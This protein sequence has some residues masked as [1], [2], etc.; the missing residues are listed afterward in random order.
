LFVIRHL[1]RDLLQKQLYETGIGTLIH[2]PIPPHRQEAYEN[3]GFGRDSLPVASA[4]ADQVLSLPMGPHLAQEQ[5]EQVIAAVK[6][7]I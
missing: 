3:A 6:R 5:V 4:L 2:Y 1:Q 7:V